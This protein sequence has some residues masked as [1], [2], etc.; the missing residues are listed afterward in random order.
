[1]IYLK[2]DILGI[3]EG[4]WEQEEMDVYHGKSTLYA[5]LQVGLALLPFRRL[6]A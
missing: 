2:L 4:T 3:S 5:T 6:F 1:V